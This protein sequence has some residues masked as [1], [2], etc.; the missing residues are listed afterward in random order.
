M[1]PHWSGVSTCLKD[2]RAD[3]NRS[4][5]PPRLLGLGLGLTVALSGVGVSAPAFAESGPGAETTTVL[6]WE[7]PLVPVAAGSEFPT[8]NLLASLVGTLESSTPA[9][10]YLLPI[11]PADLSLDDWAVIGVSPV[12]AVDI[13]AAVQ[14]DQSAYVVLNLE[15]EIVSVIGTTITVPNNPADAL[16]VHGGTATSP[17]Q[18]IED[19]IRELRRLLDELR[20]RLAP[21]P[22]TPPPGSGEDDDGG[23]W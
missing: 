16:M 4:P 3:H 19:M 20:R 8:A 2:S 15:G 11:A 12:Q 7:Y 14:A 10:I 9:S 1:G 21:V 22:P 23:E 6:A 13:L 18:T 5:I 17:G